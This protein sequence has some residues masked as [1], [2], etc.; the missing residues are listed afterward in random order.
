MET[1]SSCTESVS[2]N[3]QCTLLHCL[4]QWCTAKGSTYTGQSHLPRDNGWWCIVSCLRMCSTCGGSVLCDSVLCTVY[5]FMLCINTT[6]V[7]LHVMYRKVHKLCIQ[8]YVHIHY[9][10]HTSH[11]QQLHIHTLHYTW[12]YNTHYTT[13]TYTIYT[14]LHTD[15][16]THMHTHTRTHTPTH[17]H[18]HAH[19][20]HM[21]IKEHVHKYT[22]Q[23][24][25][26][27]WVPMKTRLAPE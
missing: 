14:T 1:S 22:Y 16:H 25:I 5:D 26:Q 24:T 4:L 8:S 7:I 19:T 9:T 15:T 10:Y 6:H 20:L 11:T 27:G 3:D 18:A 23:S 21:H 12:T 13:H 2:P 17:T